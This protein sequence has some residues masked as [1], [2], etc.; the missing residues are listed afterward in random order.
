VKT[1]ILFLEQFL[2]PD[3]LRIALTFHIPVGTKVKG[4]DEG[5]GYLCELF[6]NRLLVC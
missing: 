5:N 1:A 4:T 3:R 2:E 6:M